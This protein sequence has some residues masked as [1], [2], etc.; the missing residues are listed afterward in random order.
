MMVMTRKLPMA[1]L[2]NNFAILVWGVRKCDWPRLEGEGRLR[3]SI[4]GD[5]YD[6]DT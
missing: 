6:N 2:D 4:L 1:E 5:S 3:T